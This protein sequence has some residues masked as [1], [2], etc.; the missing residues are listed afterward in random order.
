MTNYVLLLRGINVG[1]NNRMPMKDL[2]ALL[3]NINATNPRTYIQSG[4]AVF[5][6][7]Q[8]IPTKL[9]AKID[10]ALQEHFGKPMSHC[11]LTGTQFTTLAQSH[12]HKAQAQEQKQLH[13]TLLGKIQNENG[14]LSECDEY[15][16]CSEI[17]N[18]GSDQ[19]GAPTNNLQAIYL[20]TPNGYAKTKL[21]NNTVAKIFNTSATTRN[22]RTV[23]NIAQILADS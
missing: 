18:A 12:P 17:A 5:S 21:E 22:W 8:K 11:L 10:A 15:K 9:S 2:V 1:G 3:E 20:Y 14:H 7:T 23:Q 13:L 19:I 16:K 6:H 4:N